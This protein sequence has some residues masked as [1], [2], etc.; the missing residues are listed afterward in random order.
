MLACKRPSATIEHKS[1][2]NLCIIIIISRQFGT[3]AWASDLSPDSWHCGLFVSSTFVP[4]LARNSV[5]GGKLV[6]LARSDHH[7]A[8][9]WS[10][11]TTTVNKAAISSLRNNM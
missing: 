5:L 6:A 2:F 7:P 9:K 11:Y 10:V 3:N 4:L 8:L 1:V